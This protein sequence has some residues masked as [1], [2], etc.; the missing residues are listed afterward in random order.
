[1]L[2]RDLESL[3]FV[4]IVDDILC[5]YQKVDD[6]LSMFKGVVSDKVH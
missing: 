3:S 4:I 5:T 1:V 6:I 2:C